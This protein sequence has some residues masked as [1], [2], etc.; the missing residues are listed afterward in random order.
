MKPA[1]AGPR[2][3]LATLVAAALLHASGSTMRAAS[4]SLPSLPLPADAPRTLPG[5]QLELVAQAPDLVHP[6]V[7]CTAPDGRVFVAEDPMDIRADV[8]ADASR[9]RIL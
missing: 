9:G 3:L 2:S 8:P 4:D 7:V 5:W 1:G 6:S